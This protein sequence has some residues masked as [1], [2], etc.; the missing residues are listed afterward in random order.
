M[1]IRFREI[2]LYTSG[3]GFNNK[4]FILN[5]IKIHPAAQDYKEP[6]LQEDSSIL[7]SV[8]LLHVFKI[9]GE[10]GKAS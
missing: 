7:M 6:N 9:T 1:V 8:L 2:K 3:V 10:I 5:L 4:T